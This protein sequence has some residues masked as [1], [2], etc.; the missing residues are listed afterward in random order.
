MQSVITSVAID[1][2]RLYFASSAGSFAGDVCVAG[3]FADVDVGGNAPIS[4][5]FRLQAARFASRAASRS[6][7]AADDDAAAGAVAVTA[8]AGA[9]DGGGGDDDD[10]DDD[11]ARAK[12]ASTANASVYFCFAW[13]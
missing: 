9:V 6:D 4:I 13:R 12:P 7:K 10:D 3:D 2:K 5:A 8:A 1:A 11:D